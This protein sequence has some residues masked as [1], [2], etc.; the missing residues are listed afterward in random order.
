MQVR[1]DD[2]LLQQLPAK[3][4]LFNVPMRDH[5]SFKIGGPADAMVFPESIEEVQ[6]IVVYCNSRG[7]PLFV[8]GNGS[9][10]LVRDGGIRG[11]VIK[12]SDCMDWVRVEGETIVAGCGI[13]LHR[14]AQ[15]ALDASLSGLEFASGIPGTLGGAIYMNA[16]AYEGTMKD[17]VYQVEVVDREGKHKTYIG[18]EI[19]FEYRDSIIQRNNLVAVEARVRLRGTAKSDI[20][21]KMREL[22]EKRKKKQP[23]K[24]P[25]AGSTFKRP[26]DH[27]AGKLIEEAGLMGFRI[28]GAQVSTLHAGFVVNLGGATS[29]DVINLIDEIRRR[30]YEHAGVEL[31]PEIKVV[32]EDA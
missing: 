19:A 15:V 23:L 10:L 11:V 14:L 9:N 32:G 17:V 5:T 12:I 25:S 18:D 30:V 27:F 29:A 31:T 2:F 24:M 26:P 3:K 21:A 16:G 4:V 28:G 13:T 7:I 22:D 8:L 6:A 20:L 1:Q